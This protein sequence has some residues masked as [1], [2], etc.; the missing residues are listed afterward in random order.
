METKF[1]LQVQAAH[2]LEELLR[3]KTQQIEKY[4]QKLSPK[5]SYLCR[6]QMVRSFLWMQLNKEKDN[7]HLNR[8]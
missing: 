8:R 2:D 5:S 1:E 7:L 4:G 3:L 6:H